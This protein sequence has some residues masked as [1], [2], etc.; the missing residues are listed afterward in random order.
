MMSKEKKH[1]DCPESF[2]DWAID[3][4]K[5]QMIERYNRGQ[6]K[7]G[8]YIVDRSGLHD[9]KEEIMDALFYIMVEELKLEMKQE[10]TP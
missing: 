2:R 8:D 4:I 1:P 7:Y 6:E 10:K 9:I 5:S 3:R